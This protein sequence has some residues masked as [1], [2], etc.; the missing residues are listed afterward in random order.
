MVS[1]AEDA[2]QFF[3]DDFHDLLARA[4]AFE[5]FAAQGTIFN[6]VH[7]ISRNS[8]VHVGFQQ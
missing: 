7:E 1:G 4:E 8:E 2:G 3:V 6:R 5:H